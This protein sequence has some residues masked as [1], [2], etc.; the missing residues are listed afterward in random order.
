MS[1]TAERE[2]AAAA[3]ALA[4]NQM[5]DDAR[6]SGDAAGAAST[7]E[8]NPVPASSD[9]RPRVK[10]CSIEWWT[11]EVDKAKK[12]LASAEEEID[13]S[14]LAT[15]CVR[16]LTN[17]SASEKKRGRMMIQRRLRTGLKIEDEQ[18]PLD[19]S[20]LHI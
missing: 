6:R 8:A 3:A 11:K 16:N 1:D 19:F 4:N 14:V 10:R 5:S 20:S 12:Q 9:P 2:A 18:F 17:H 7:Q 13:V 15:Q